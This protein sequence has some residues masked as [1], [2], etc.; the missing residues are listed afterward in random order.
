MALA[1]DA[2]DATNNAVDAAINVRDPGTT[3]ARICLA[4]FGSWLEI[5]RTQTADFPNPY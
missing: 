4:Y 3:Q 2:S 5:S 1:L